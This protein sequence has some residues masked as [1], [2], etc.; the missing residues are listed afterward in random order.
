MTPAPQVEEYL[1]YCRSEK[2]LAANTLSAYRRD[3]AKLAAA[4]ARQGQTPLDL[5]ADDLRSFVDSLY[6]AK[7]SS[8][9][10][11]RHITTLRNFYN[12]FLGQGKIQIDPTADLAS[13]R[14]GKQLP[15]HLTLDEVDR[16]LEAQ[17]PGSLLGL[18]DHAMLQLLYATG[19]RVSELVSTQQSHLNTDMGFLRLTGKGGK[20]RLVPVGRVALGAIE[21][22]A[23]DGREKILKGRPSEFLFVTARG[24]AMTRQAFWHLLRRYGRKAGIRSRLT[25][26]VLRHS[27]AT[28]LLE[29]GADLRSLQMM[30]G[31]E[32]ISTTQIYTHVLRERLRKV[33]DEHH[34]RS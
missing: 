5:A 34:P 33:Y 16:L 17:D 28:H 3:L 10:I 19:L 6:R 31:H 22:Y 29:R 32:D 18:R 4:A 12:F 14:Q 30:L 15:K 26:H 2:G 20:Q 21:T 9:S 25:P 23:R 7:L 8:R 13:P 11:A 27:F 24:G 1:F